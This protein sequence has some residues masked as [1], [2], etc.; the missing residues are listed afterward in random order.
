[1]SD[2]SLEHLWIQVIDGWFEGNVVQWADR[3]F[4]P[5]NI[6]EIFNYCSRLGRT[7]EF[8]LMTSEEQALADVHPFMCQPRASLAEK[9]ATAQS[10]FS[11]LEREL[12]NKRALVTSLKRQRQ[13]CKHEYL[14]P[15]R[16]FEHEGGTCKHCAG[17][18][19]AM[20]GGFYS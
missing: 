12:A 3:F 16:G 8:S 1:M 20:K 17:N 7:V 6:D 9:I 11:R 19:L 18:E 5:D 14:Q 10:D 15:V 4:K 13:F 2:I